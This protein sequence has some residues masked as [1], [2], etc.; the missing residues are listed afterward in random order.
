MSHHRDSKVYCTSKKLPQK[1]IHIPIYLSGGSRAILER[2]QD[3]TQLLG[4]RTAAACFYPPQ[5]I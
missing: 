2:Y 1:Q 5:I 4:T 3:Q